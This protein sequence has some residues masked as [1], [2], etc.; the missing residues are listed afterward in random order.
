MT[1]DKPGI[2]EWAITYADGSIRRY[3]GKYTRQN[4]PM[5][6]YHANVERILDGRPYRKAAPTGFRGVH[7]ELAEATREDRTIVLTILEN[8]APQ[9][10][11][12]REQALIRERDATLN[13]GLSVLVIQ[14]QLA[15]HP[16]VDG[17]VKVGQ[18]CTGIVHEG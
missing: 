9:D 15:F 18:S 4:R 3:V 11:H 17:T 5:R 14:E 1:L 8:A 16:H 10:L 6:E 12:R 2:Y 13:G 7:K